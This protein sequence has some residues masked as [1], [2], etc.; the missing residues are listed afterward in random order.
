[1]PTPFTGDNSLITQVE[2]PHIFS[3]SYILSLIE[4]SPSLFSQAETHALL[5]FLLKRVVA[6][7]NALEPLQASMY[8]LAEHE[9]MLIPLRPLLEHPLDATP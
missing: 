6:L 8:T 7:E 1:M 3:S 2:Q 4:Y 9:K 5:L